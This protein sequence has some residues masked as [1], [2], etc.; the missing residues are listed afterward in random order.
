M[1]RVRNHCCQGYVTIRYF[2]IVVGVDA[3]VNNA[4]ALSVAMDM[5]QC[6]PLHFY[7]ATKYSVLLLKIIRVKR[8]ECVS[9]FLP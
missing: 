8:Y 6:V 2:F 3:A 7:R 1:T 5:Q 9:V 4:E